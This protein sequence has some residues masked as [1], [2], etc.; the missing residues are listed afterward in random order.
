MFTFRNVLFGVCFNK[1][2]FIFFLLKAPLYNFFPSKSNIVISGND[3][4]IT[5]VFI[6][7]G[8]LPPHVRTK[9]QT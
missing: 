9:T 4:L 8:Q 7:I 6:M 1:A 5:K 2:S 3:L